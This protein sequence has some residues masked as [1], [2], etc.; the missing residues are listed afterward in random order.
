M[1][2]LAGWENFYVIL[3]SSAGALIGL[4]FVVMALLADLPRTAPQAEAGNAFATP[5]VV[6]FG[7]V[8][9]LSALLSAPWHG[10]GIPTVALGILGLCGVVY[11]LIVAR[12]MR[13]Q[14]IYRPVFEDWLF[15]AI[16]PFGGYAML[17]ASAYEA[18]IYAYGP[19]FGVAA[20]V[21]L[22]LLVGIH[23]AWDAA[24]YHIF[25]VRSKR[26]HTEPD[27]L[28]PTSSAESRGSQ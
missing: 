26:H 3:G 11:S 2:P 10:K 22:L 16:L 27:S 5:N 6:H 23:N 7:A 14:T 25:V 12:R 18:R 20:A 15:H 8:L 19:M 21:L 1:N 28:Q 4:Q 24:T 13:A 17:A 9:L